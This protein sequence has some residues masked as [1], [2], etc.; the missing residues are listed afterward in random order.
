MYII[1]SW[2]YIQQ[3]PTC[4]RNNNLVITLSLL[5]IRSYTGETQSR[6]VV[7]TLSPGPKYSDPCEL[8]KSLCT[9]LTRDPCTLG[10][11]RTL[12][13]A[14]PRLGHHRRSPRRHGRAANCRCSL[15]RGNAPHH[16][17]R[18]RGPYLSPKQS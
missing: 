12:E 6:N 16:L 17:K 14:R 1:V 10:P 15:V 13:R 18:A 4:S 3:S 9:L 2:A 7:E 8:C 11:S 5:L